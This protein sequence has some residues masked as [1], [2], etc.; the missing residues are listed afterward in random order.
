[1]N[2]QP[3]PQNENK[4]TLL[5]ETVFRTDTIKLNSA[6]RQRRCFYLI[7]SWTLQAFCALLIAVAL[8][9]GAVQFLRLWG[10]LGVTSQEPPGLTYYVEDEDTAL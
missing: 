8:A 6:R 7:L 3:T 10:I 2:D 4:A 5:A 9:W 1:M